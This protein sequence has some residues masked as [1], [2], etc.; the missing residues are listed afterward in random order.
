MPATG[1][2]HV[3]PVVD[4]FLQ[5]TSTCFGGDARVVR[6]HAREVL[7]PPRDVVQVVPS[8]DPEHFDGSTT[9]SGITDWR[10]TAT[11]GT[12]RQTRTD[13]CS[14]ADRTAARVWTQL[15]WGNQSPNVFG[16]PL[17]NHAGCPAS[18]DPVNAAALH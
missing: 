1:D 2:A 14:G 13:A 6:E 7:S 18:K 12:S 10:F 8:L 3:E 17:L 16:L 9:H 11:P 15:T 4:A 5:P